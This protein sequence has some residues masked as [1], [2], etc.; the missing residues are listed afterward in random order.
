MRLP[1]ITHADLRASDT[2]RALRPSCPVVDT[3]PFGWGQA[4]SAC[5]DPTEPDADCVY[6][7]A[8]DDH[9]D[10]GIGELAAHEAIADESDS[11]EFTHHH[12]VSELQRDAEIRDQEGK[13]MEHSAEAGR[14][15]S[16]R[17]ATQW[18]TAA[19]DASIIGQRF[20]ETHADSRAKR[21]CEPD[22]ESTQGPA[23]QARRCEDRGQCRDRTIHQPQETWLDLL[24]HQ[25]I[26]TT[27]P[28]R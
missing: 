9:L 14:D 6:D 22:K 23:G 24:E 26:A 12:H 4:H 15:A 10:D 16:D 25:G 17:A 2:Q 11:D 13:G 18:T 20:G 19:S 8:S 27:I 28:Q 3:S 1:L 5:T 21:R 7:T